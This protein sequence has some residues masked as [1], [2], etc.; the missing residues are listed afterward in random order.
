MFIM[1]Y[2][3]QPVRKSSSWPNVDFIMILFHRLRK[4]NDFSKKDEILA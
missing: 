2:E 3:I 4:V 1:R